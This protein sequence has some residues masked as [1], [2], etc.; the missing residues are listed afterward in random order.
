MKR[1]ARLTASAPSL[2]ACSALAL[3]GCGGD[4]A[5]QS[6]SQLADVTVA[7]TAIPSDG[8]CAHIIVTRLADFQSTEFRGLLAG[9]TIKAPLGEGRVTATAYPTPCGSEPAAAPWTADAQTVTFVKGANT[10]TLNFHQTVDAG[11]DANFDDTKPL[12]VRAG[13]QV[14][15][16]RN[17][18]D[19]A[20]PNFA[21][22]GWEVKQL[23]LPPAAVSETV[24]FSLEGKG[25]DYTPRGMARMPDGSF[26]FQLAE[27][28]TPLY[29]FSATGA[30]LGRWPISYPAGTTQWD[31][32]DGLEAIDATHL[33]RT[34]WLNKPIGCDAAGDHC[35]QSGIEILEKKT[36]ADGSTF[37]QVV[38][39]IFL[40]ELATEALNAEYPVG[41]APVGARFAVTLLP[42]SGTT[43]V[44]LNADGTV[45]AGPK[46]MPAAEDIEGLFDDGAGR[47]VGV[48]YTG[49]LTTYSDSDLTPRAGETGNVG[50]G[51]GFGAPLRLA[52]RS[53]GAGSFLAWNGQ[54]LVSAT[55]DFGAIGD[56]GIDSSSSVNTISDLEYKPDTDELLL[57]DRFPAGGAPTVVAYNLTTRAQT[58][59]VTLQPGLSVTLRP[60][61]VAYIPSTHQLV[62]HYRRAG[63]ADAT[64]DAVAFVH[65]ADGTLATKFDLAKWGFTRINSVRYDSVHDQLVF[66][67]VD[68]GGVVRI[69]TTDRAF[70][71]KRS[72]RTDALPDLAELAPMSTGPFAGDFGVVQSQPSYFARVLLP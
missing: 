64:L 20:G 50:E 55:P 69:V 39:Q 44:L 4:H 46:A 31:N 15:I 57:L 6:S 45:A 37:V 23:T 40:P 5:L 43:L 53:A 14:R 36:A 71:P 59:T 26:V 12:V 48:G 2:V 7:A 49:N 13:S 51:V 38:N 33:V 1:L 10:V 29:S 28:L 65:N 21:L 63:S 27:V 3:I 22:D 61:G 34:G 9:A 41:V 60:W 17:G 42:D 32:T 35:K 24:V 25:V 56:L 19:T 30:P 66:L 47:L 70:A 8:Q 67:A 11:I 72:Y 52:W 62:A 68:A 58:T 16:S 18:E 54:R